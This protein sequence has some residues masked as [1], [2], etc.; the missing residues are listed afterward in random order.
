MTP[1][2]RMLLAPVGKNLPATKAVGFSAIAHRRLSNLWRSSEQYVAI[3]LILMALAA[4]S[5]QLDE[6]VVTPSTQ[7]ASAQVQGSR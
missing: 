2:S 3:A 1:A 7:S 4:L 5:T 6:T